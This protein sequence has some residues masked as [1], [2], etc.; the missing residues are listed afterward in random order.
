VWNIGKAWLRFF[1]DQPVKIKHNTQKKVD[2]LIDAA[3]PQPA[4]ATV[5]KRLL[6]L[7]KNERVKFEDLLQVEEL[8]GGGEEQTKFYSS[9]MVHLKNVSG[10]LGSHGGM[11]KFELKN[12]FHRELNYR[13][14]LEYLD[15]DNFLENVKSDLRKEYMNEDEGQKFNCEFT[16]YMISL[17]SYKNMVRLNEDRLG[18]G[19]RFEEI[20]DRIYYAR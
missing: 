6:C 4:I 19:E 15:V 12:P 10:I 8:S 20:N 17:Q 11:S 14:F 1:T 13:R 7:D 9:L 2:R 5:M 16:L 18:Q 3:V